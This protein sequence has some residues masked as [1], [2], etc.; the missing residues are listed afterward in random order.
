[1][2]SEPEAVASGLQ[3]Y[4]LAREYRSGYK[5]R[6]VWNDTDAPLA[7]LISFRSY[8]TWLHGDER[9][10]IDRFHNRYKSPYINPNPKWQAYNEQRL[11]TAPLL[12]EA[13]HRKAVEGAIR[14]T[15]DLRKWWLQ[16]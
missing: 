11:R 16:P 6:P 3:H 2:K 10:S 7:Y 13:Q 14:E 9:G 5:T 1:M 4:L 8:G 15:C 12:L